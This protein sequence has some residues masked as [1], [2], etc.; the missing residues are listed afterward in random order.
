MCPARPRCW[1]SVAS[2]AC[3]IKS[4]A[5]LLSLPRQEELPRLEELKKRGEANGLTGLRLI[6]SGELR[7]LEPHAAGLQALLVPSTGVTDY[8]AVCEKY[9]E[10]ITRPGSDRSL[11][12]T[13]TGHQ[14]LG[15]WDGGRNSAGC[16]FRKRS[17]QLCRTL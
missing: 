17:H 15:R 5:R 12:S 6:D 4:A 14:A 8:A 13:R 9:A 7:E 1:N 11:L 10:L 2:T 3:H 16:V